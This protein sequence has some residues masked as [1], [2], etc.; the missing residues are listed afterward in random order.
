MN[1]KSTTRTKARAA[2]PG[3]PKQGPILPQRRSPHSAIGE[4]PCR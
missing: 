1:N 2:A 4:L 3:R